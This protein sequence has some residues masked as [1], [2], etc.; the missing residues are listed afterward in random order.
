[1]NGSDH[2]TIDSQ[3]LQIYEL[4]VVN[5]RSMGKGKIMLGGKTYWESILTQCYAESVLCDSSLRIKGLSPLKL[6]LPPNSS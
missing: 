1:M 2:K 4:D 5:P 6:L 3:R